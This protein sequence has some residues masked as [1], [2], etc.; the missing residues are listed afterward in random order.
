MGD[1]EANWNR[2]VLGR[3]VALLLALA[4]LADLAAGVCARRRRQVLGI[5]NDGEAEA[6][7]FVIGMASGAEVPAD[8]LEP[9]RDAACLAVRLRAMALILCVL[10]AQAPSAARVAAGPQAG[11]E[12]PAGRADRHAV[13]PAADTS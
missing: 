12:R 5:L 9:S 3:I 6:R 2:D 4:D 1:R 11:R 7:A 8:A 13:P 10:L